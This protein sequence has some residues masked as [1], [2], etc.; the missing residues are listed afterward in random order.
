MVNDCTEEIRKLSNEIIDKMF[1]YHF[2]PGRG[3]QYDNPGKEWE[4]NTH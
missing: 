4:Y 2:T 1:E 3:N